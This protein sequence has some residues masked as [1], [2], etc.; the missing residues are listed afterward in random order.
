M[1]LL[2]NKIAIACIFTGSKVV[3]CFIH[4]QKNKIFCLTIFFWMLTYV[5]SLVFPMRFTCLGSF[6]RIRHT[7]GALMSS[8]AQLW[9]TLSWCWKGKKAHITILLFIPNVPK[10][11]LRCNHKGLLWTF[12]QRTTINTAWFAS[13]ICMS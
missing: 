13:T 7:L 1:Y 3:V 8:G 6:S 5:N 12:L 11:F 9:Q 10:E 4:C 2:K